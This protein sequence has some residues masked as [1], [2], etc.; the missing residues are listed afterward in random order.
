M[1]SNITIL[2]S[3]PLNSPAYNK[4]EYAV[5]ENDAPSL[6]KP[7]YHFIFDLVTE[8]NGTVRFDPIP[9]PELSYGLKNVGATIE[10]FIAENIAPFNSDVSFS[11]TTKQQILKYHIEILSAW[12]VAGVFTIDPD[13]VGPVV[14]ADK[15]AWSASFRE[16]EWI[17]QINDTTPFNTWLLNT[18]NGV[19]GE[20]LTV[21][22]TPKVSILDLGWHW[23]LTDVT[24][25]IKVLEVKTFDSSGNS[26]QTVRSVNATSNAPTTARLR[27]VTTSPQ[28]LNNIVA[29]L[30]LGSQ[31]IIGTDVASYT[32]QVLNAAFAPVSEILSFT[33]DEGCRYEIFR[34]HFENELGGFDSF[35]FTL[36]NQRS[37][38]SQKKKYTRAGNNV[39][40]SG[41]VYKHEDNGTVA[42]YVK[43]QNKIKLESDY[44]TNEENSWLRELINSPQIYLEFTNT[45]GDRNFKPV[46]MGTNNWTDKEISIDKLFRLTLEIDL[47][48]EDYRQRR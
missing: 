40:T 22:K 32:V 37:S 48:H 12:D 1:A 28:S 2:T 20:F 41:L 45:K 17:E 10:G 7:N 16:D 6:A 27:T 3:P 14:G 36:R 33:I 29:G 39:Q 43:T 19:N 9:E 15:Y 5:K 11:F 30:L 18:A 8:I 13:G 44:L 34:L 24:T 25:D 38:Q 26:I 47:A 31:P 4:I 23:C 42:Y 21:Y 35:N 46:F